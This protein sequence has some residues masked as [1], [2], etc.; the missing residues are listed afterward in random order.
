MKS[1][2]LIRSFCLC[3][4]LMLSW[5]VSAE[6]DNSIEA[7][8]K[9]NEKIRKLFSTHALRD[10][11]GKDAA[12]FDFAKLQEEAETGR[13]FYDIYVNDRFTIHQQVEIFRTDSGTLD[14]K[15]PAQVL[16]VQALR[17]NELPQLSSVKPTDYVSHV[18][19]LI[20]GAS[21]KF[22]TLKSRADISIPRSW[23]KA[24]GL[25]SDVV[26]SERWTYGIPALTVNYRA[27]ADVRRYDYETTRHAY[28][29]LDA[30][31]NFNEWRF[32]ANGSFSYDDNKQDGAE[33]DFDR[34]DL[35]A[36]RVFGHSKT[37]IKLGEIYSQS[38][39]MDSIPLIGVEFYDDES[40]LAS[41][42]RSYTPV[43][44]GIAQTAARVT[45]RQFGRIVFER[46]VAAGPFSFEDLPGLT[47]GT[48][49][50]V[51]ITEQNGSERTFTVPYVTTPLLLRA[52]R[53]HFNGA[54]GRWRDDHDGNGERPWVATGSVGYGLPFDTSVFT[55]GVFSED[56]Q[57]A[58][59]GVASNLGSPGALSLQVDHARFDLPF[60]EHEDNG[61]RLRLQWSNRFNA[62]GSY[63]SASWRR[64]LSGRYLSLSETLS[65]RNSKRWF[66]TNF[67]GALRDEATLALTQPM[68][69]W[70]SFSLSGSLYRYEDKRSRQN[71]TFSH[72]V[73]WQ[74]VTATLSVQHYRNKLTA[75][76]QDKETLCFLNFS[77]PLSLLAGYKASSHS[78]NLG[79]QRDGNHEYEFTEGING[80]FGEN[81]RWSYSLSTSQGSGD[82]SYYASIS[83]EAE[84]GRFTL[85]SSHDDFS[86]AFTGS[87]DGSIIATSNGVF[88]AR[89]L[90][91]AS[92][93]LDIPDAPEARP[94]QYSVS[95]RIGDK[96]LITGLNNYR[97][98]EVAINPNTIPA[99]VVMPVY[100]KR[101]VPADD[102]ILEVEY[103][104]MKGWQFVPEIIFENG[105]RL[106]FGTTVRI[107]GKDLLSQMD[108]VLN[109]R[110]RA[111]FP[112][113]P[114]Q[115]TI[116]AI[117][118]ENQER[119]TCWASYDIQQDVGKQKEGRAIRKTLTCVPASALK[120]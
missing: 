29:D 46:N 71:L 83:K 6:S 115:G 98:N 15:V 1:A 87:M 7:R 72:T 28:L 119:K 62:T 105:D 36:T 102:A 99:N 45:V 37:R 88:P 11:F 118:E 4:L 81:N 18:E 114:V 67:D 101:L 10:I 103:E 82:Q 90:S 30:R 85:A 32:I 65:R 106:P 104:T 25:Q 76:Y 69:K 100:V 117:W 60:D 77:I 109:E 93:L 78:L 79:A 68:G 92:A 39:Y 89:T 110:A 31:F 112:S 26:P 34:G 27:N 56:Y 40:M 97:I 48:D 91:G 54:V 13:R 94:D 74:G 80:T 51:T 44:S 70:G 22:D 52:G 23:F 59:L 63:I 108:T 33:S 116:E 57:N 35:Y 24:F 64:Y 61:T 53:L 17:F 55:G 86:T 3:S 47:S 120:D 113:A 95:S 96:I 43:V 84:Y 14:I 5:P 73:N 50:E 49:L 75:G 2:A 38:F 41:L 111:Y 20:P 19:E 9:E 21:V 42:E 8:D 58:T 107:V 66:Y 12:S 16:L